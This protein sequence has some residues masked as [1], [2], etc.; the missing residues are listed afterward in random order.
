M[1]EHFKITTL[2]ITFMCC[3]EGVLPPYLGSTIRGIMGHCIREFTCNACKDEKCYLC[4]NREN[5]LY[6]KFFSNTGKEAGAVNPYTI[7]VLNNGKTQWV[8]GDECTFELTLFGFA[9]ENAGIYLDAIVEMEKK[10]WGASR[11][12]FKL[13]RVS[14]AYTGRLIYTQGRMWLRNM[15]CHLME[16]GKQEASAVMVS[17]DTPLRI[18]TQKSLCRLPTFANLMQ[19][20]SRR[21]SLLSQIY[22]GQKVQWNDKEIIKQAEKVNITGH[23]L[24]YVDF[25][26]FSINQESNKLELPAM[27]GWVMYEGELSYLSPILEA[28][29]IIHIGK[30]TTIGFGHYETFYNK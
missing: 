2:K 5:C 1:W 11:L 23:M 8:K 16:V 3:E 14:D 4:K 22:T 13:T 9:A 30:G 15:E 28:G 6:V 18:M 17:F 27:E 20:T 12:P 26:R 24:R 7:H 29:K 19:F 10:G 21:L 25:K